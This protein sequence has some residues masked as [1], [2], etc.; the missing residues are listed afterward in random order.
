MMNDDD[1]NDDGNKSTDNNGKCLMTL[2]I[3]S[4]LCSLHQFA[5]HKMMIRTMI[6][7]TII[8]M[9]KLHCND[10][11]DDFLHLVF[12]APVCRSHS[13]PFSRQAAA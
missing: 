10:A 9:M 1:D 12:F 6:N 8:N 13:A 7:M 4:T 3:C 11:F 2:M 5:D